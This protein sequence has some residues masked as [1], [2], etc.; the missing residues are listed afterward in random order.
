MLTI[1]TGGSAGV[2]DAY[3]YTAFGEELTATGSTENP[4]RFG[5]QFGY[6][7]D[8]P[9][10]LYVRSRYLQPAT[11]RWLSVD[12][13]P[14]E[15]RY[16]YAYNNPLVYQDPDGE[17]ARRTDPRLYGLPKP[18]PRS[19]GN[20]LEDFLEQQRYRDYLLRRGYWQRRQMDLWEA[21]QP[22]HDVG[23]LQAGYN[24][25]V[26]GKAFP[27]QAEYD[28]AYSSVAQ[29]LEEALAG[30]NIIDL[31]LHR[32]E[33]QW[34][35][36]ARAAYRQ[37][38]Q[39]TIGGKTTLAAFRA[40]LPPGMR[41]AI[42]AVNQEAI[43][44][45][46]SPNLQRIAPPDVNDPKLIL[47]TAGFSF[48]A[49]KFLVDA[50]GP[51][52]TAKD[53]LS[54]TY[55]LSGD[56][57][58]WADLQAFLKQLGGDL[59]A[60]VSGPGLPA[61]GAYVAGREAAI[62]LCTAISLMLIAVTLGLGAAKLGRG[63]RTAFNK[64]RVNTAELAQRTAAGR[65]L[66]GQVSQVTLEP[67]RRLATA[68]GPGGNVVRPPSPRL[69]GKEK[70]TAFA[71]EFKGDPAAKNV[72]SHTKKELGPR[73][74]AVSTP[75]VRAASTQLSDLVRSRV[76]ELKES[77]PTSQKGRVTMAVAV[78]EHAD[79]TR[80]VV[81][82]SSEPYLRRGV[83]L[84]QGE[85]LAV[86]AGHAEQNLVEYST[87]SNAKVLAIGAT[88]PVCSACQLALNRIGAKIETPLK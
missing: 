74:E 62:L 8:T 29:G 42:T 14:G 56:P 64:L 3:R 1:G 13:V 54:L 51:H 80:E 78:I 52:S 15:P 73:T 20:P 5:G 27:T 6:Y 22:L 60:Y 71:E 49:G 76:T 32:L 47:W 88:R 81:I 55:Y 36:A 35:E 87:R 43:H 45:R 44:S 68:G 65:R 72:I 41:F 77:I 16:R 50:L 2:S 70:W 39:Q 69:H 25:A 31:A 26:T 85:K 4:H 84:R 40:L 24:L 9:D 12:P 7:R 10:R 21:E 48:A 37:A 58:I 17:Q 75:S 86:G 23:L 34:F 38:Q 53:L 61:V 19:T 59:A 67:A 82:A 46:L 83:R 63:A 57:G 66:Q 79:G 18:R 28:A 33:K 30:A 11:G